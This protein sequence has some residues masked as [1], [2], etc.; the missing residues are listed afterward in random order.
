MSGM[1]LYIRRTTVKA[2]R[3]TLYTCIR[4]N[5]YTIIGVLHTHTRNV[6]LSSEL[7]QCHSLHP[8]RMMRNGVMFSDACSLDEHAQQLAS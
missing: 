1:A 2:G 8:M 6:R 5:W 4:V 3:P 7:S